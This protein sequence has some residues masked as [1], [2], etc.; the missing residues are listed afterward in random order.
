MEEEDTTSKECESQVSRPHSI[1]NQ[2]LDKAETMVLEMQKILDDF[3]KQA[4]EEK[5]TMVR[6]IEGGNDGEEWYEHFDDTFQRPFYVEAKTTATKSILF[7]C[8]IH[9]SLCRKESV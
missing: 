9:A 8:L 2:S 6:R 4:V 7:R 5:T 3:K 1:S